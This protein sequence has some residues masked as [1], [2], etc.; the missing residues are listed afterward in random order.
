M[1]DSAAEG[2]PRDHAR[3]VILQEAGAVRELADRLD[4]RFDT[5]VR[6]ILECRG[7]VIL[8]GI[9]KSGHVAR[10]LAATFTS[11]GTPSF[12]L[13]PAEGGHGDLGLL[14][15]GDLLIALSKSG[16]TSELETIFPAVSRLG[17]NSI[18]LTGRLEASLT[19]RA[20]VALDCSV[21]A[22]ACP[23]NLA[24]TT[25]ATVA[26]VMGHALAVAVLKAR[27]FTSADFANLHPAGSLG[28]RLLLCVRDKMHTGAE[29]PRVEPSLPVRQTL[30]EITGKRLGCA[31]VCHADGTIAGIFTDGDLRRLTQRE[32]NFLNLETAAV[33]SPEPRTIG[34]DALLDEALSLMEAHAIT[35][36]PVIDEHHRLCGIIH[37]HDILG[38][39]AVQRS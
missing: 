23:H 3:E 30:V 9:G 17:L 14:Q 20:T 1:T 36:L 15:R 8:T 26:M 28:Q 24:P 34:P 22:E 18:L 32:E 12:F 11:T 6:L 2:Q 38:G 5:A 31:I 27:N 7:R 16:S 13:H 29:I 4:D 39:V 19:Q 25:S 35:A 37:M 21:A 33:M 10:K